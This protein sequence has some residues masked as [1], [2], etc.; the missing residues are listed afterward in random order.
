VIEPS[1]LPQKVLLRSSK[2]APCFTVFA[3]GPIYLALPT[4]DLPE[5]GARMNFAM[6]P[7]FRLFLIPDV[8]HGGGGS[9]FPEFDSFTALENW[10]ERGIAPTKGLSRNK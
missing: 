2:Q 1:G 10:V 5:N 7:F 4:G 3:E 6:E 9:G 8:H